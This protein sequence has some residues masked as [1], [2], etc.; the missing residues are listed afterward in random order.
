VIALT[1]A[2]A[3]IQNRTGAI[4]IYRTHNKPALGRLGDSLSDFR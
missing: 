1:E 2:N 3:A 4:T